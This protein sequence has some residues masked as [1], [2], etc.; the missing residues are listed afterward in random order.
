MKK[1]LSIFI[2]L[3]VFAA[4]AWARP[5]QDQLVKID[6]ARTAAENWINIIIQKKGS[7][8][9]S[10]SAYID[11]IQ[12]FKHLGESIGYFCNVEPKGYI[13]LTLRKEFSPVKAYSA[14]NNLNPDSD[15]GIADF[16]KGKMA[17]KIRQIEKRLG[18]LS[19]ISSE[20]L[21]NI[22][23]TN[24]QLL[25]DKLTQGII[26][27]NYN[28]LEGIGE[29]ADIDIDAVPMNY[30]E[31]DFL[32]SSY[33][34]QFT[35][36]NAMTPPIYLPTTPPT[37]VCKHTLVGCVATAGAQ[38][39]RYWNWPPYGEVLSGCSE[40][41][42]DWPNMLDEID[43][44]SP[45]ENINAVAELSYEVGVHVD[46]DYGCDGS[47]ADTSEMVSVFSRFRSSG[48]V[49]E[50]VYNIGTYP[51]YW[52]GLMKD[53]LNQNRPILYYWKGSPGHALVLD[54]WQELNAFN[55][56]V[57]Q[58]HLNRGSGDPN[59]NNTWYTLDESLFGNEH[60]PDG[61]IKKI[62]PAQSL[63]GT[64]S[65]TYTRN[66]QFPYYYFD[67]NT[68][69]ENAVFES[70]SNL[71][72]LKGVKLTNTSTSN[73]IIRIEGVGSFIETK[74]RLFTLSDTVTSNGIYV[75]NGVI[76]L[77]RNGSIKIY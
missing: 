5:N 22:L 57:R 77:Y 6:E 7:W 12:F 35:P 8:G 52:Y 21:E 50:V 47:S 16:I 30:Q 71:Q 60:L 31:G 9:G 27:R 41:P 65:G 3:S 56:P 51:D 15:V 32:L 26:D 14:I 74:A 72:F 58:F 28:T 59:L 44:E 11:D 70:G 61:M 20:A 49:T 17:D 76:E 48:Y 63:L 37:L 36:Y 33:W 23:K 46:M 42:Y 55:P 24:H 4:T 43:R 53:E 69:G 54:G 45:L 75:S 67:R 19:K 62:Y 10:E 64:V 73:G 29:E 25:W 68:E 18:P 39:M 38:I 2:I 1:I 34:G 13:I 66:P 40:D